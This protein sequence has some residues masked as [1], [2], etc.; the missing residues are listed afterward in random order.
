MS[1]V[2]VSPGV[3]LN[4]ESLGNGPPLVLVHGSSDDY[5]GWQAQVESFSKRYRGISYSR[6]YNYPNQ[7]EPIDHYSAKV[8]ASDLYGL[9]MALELQMVTIVGHSYGAFTTLFLLIEHP[10]AVEAAVL[11]EPP[12][13]S[14]LREYPGSRNVGRSMERE[15]QSNLVAPMTTAFRAGDQAAGLKAFYDYVAGPA[16]YNLLPEA[17]RRQGLENA[18]EWQVMLTRGEFFPEIDAT[19]VSQIKTPILLLAGSNTNAFLMMIHE[20]LSRMLTN[21]ESVI[22]QDAP[23][24]MFDTHREASEDAVL[25]FLTRRI[26]VKQ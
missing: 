21:S 5:R 23:H 2:E 7:N 18:T 15:V 26:G 12:A 9:I 22:I 10:E 14:L 19:R 4:Y 20:T 24:P 16:L 3:V 11:A 1:S 13:I 6:R 17:V 25:A 8:D